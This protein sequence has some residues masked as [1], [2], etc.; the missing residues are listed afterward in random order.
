MRVLIVDDHPMIVEAVGIAIEA[1]RPDVQRDSVSSV[2]ALEQLEGVA[3]DLI[4]LDMSLPGASGL[5]ALTRVL[6]RWPQALIVIFS[7]TDDSA[8]IRRAL[9]AGAKGFIPKTSPHAVL[10]DALRLVLDGGTYIPPDILDDIV[11]PQPIRSHA[12]SGIGLETND[13]PMSSRQSGHEPPLSGRQRQIVELLAK[14]MT[15]KEI[16][17]ELGISQNTVKT[18]VASIF[19]SLGVKNRAQV[20]AVTQAWLLSQQSR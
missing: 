15:T 19:R 10:I 6:K 13:Y 3:P 1:L 14:G 5:D 9:T 4:L 17:R 11:S 7:A 18:H 16:C 12:R 8:S 20:V 2:E